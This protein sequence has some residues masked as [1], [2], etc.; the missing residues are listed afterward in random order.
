MGGNPGIA[1]VLPKAPIR[2]RAMLGVPIAPK[3]SGGKLMKRKTR[4]VHY[5]WTYVKPGG[6][7]PSKVPGDVVDPSSE[8]GDLGKENETACVMKFLR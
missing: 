1:P 3:I 5:R 6:R 4:F 7:G 2:P 8:L